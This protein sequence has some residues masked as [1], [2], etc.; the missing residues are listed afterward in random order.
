LALLRC[1]DE[2]DAARDVDS[3]DQLKVDRDLLRSSR[4]WVQRKDEHQQTCAHSGGGF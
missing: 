3:K 2:I 4:P 1:L